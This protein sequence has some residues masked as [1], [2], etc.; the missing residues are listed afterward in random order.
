MCAEW[1]SG[2]VHGYDFMCNAC[3]RLTGKRCYTFA[4]V[5]DYSTMNCISTGHSR[6]NDD[7]CC[8]ERN[9]LFKVMHDD[10]PKILTVFR[11]YRN[12]NKTKYHNSRPCSQCVLA[13]SLCNV[14][15]VGFSMPGSMLHFDWDRP[16]NIRPERTTS[17]GVIIRFE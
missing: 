13:M 16:D 8:A 9:A 10:C 14:R 11:V 2:I 1:A 6:Q 12:K 17:N 5:Y 3:A 15:L 7:S 4:M